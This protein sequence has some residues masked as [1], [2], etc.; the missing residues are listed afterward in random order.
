MSDSWKRAARGAIGA[1]ATGGI[2]PKM[3]SETDAHDAELFRVARALVADPDLAPVASDPVTQSAAAQVAS[4]F[5]DYDRQL[6]A[7]VRSKPRDSSSRAGVE[8]AVAHRIELA[9]RQLVGG[10]AAV[11]AAARP[12]R[13][14]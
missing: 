6:F 3:P 9:R 10:I 14:A 11:T 2:L 5:D 12:R 13:R 7:R 8:A 1:V 4:E